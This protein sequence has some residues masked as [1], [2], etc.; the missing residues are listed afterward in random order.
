MP[1][2]SASRWVRLTVW[3]SSE[4]KQFLTGTRAGLISSSEIQYPPCRPTLALTFLL[5]LQTILPRLSGI[6]TVCKSGIQSVSAASQSVLKRLAGAMYR[7][8]LLLATA[9]ASAGQCGATEGAARGSVPNI[10]GQTFTA[11]NCLMNIDNLFVEEG[12][13]QTKTQHNYGDRL[14][15][16]ADTWSTVAAARAALPAITVTG[17]NAYY[18]STAGCSDYGDYFRIG[19]NS[20]KEAADLVRDHGGSV[21]IDDVE[22]V[23]LQPNSTAPHSRILYV[24]GNKIYSNASNIEQSLLAAG[25]SELSLVVN[26]STS[27]EEGDL[28]SSHK[29]VITGT[30]GVVTAVL[31]TDKSLPPVCWCRNTLLSTT[32]SYYDTCLN[33][34]SDGINKMIR[35][36]G[37]MGEPLGLGEATVVTPVSAAEIKA[38]NK[39]AD[40]HFVLAGCGKTNLRIIAGLAAGEGSGGGGGAPDPGLLKCISSLYEAIT[41]T[42]PSPAVKPAARDKRWS[43]MSFLFGESF[44]VRQINDNV[45]TITRNQE[46]L[47]NDEQT[48]LEN[49]HRISQFVDVL[50]AKDEDVM[51]QMIQITDQ[52][53]LHG[54]ILRRVNRAHTGNAKQ[55][56]SLLSVTELYYRVVDLGEGVDVELSSLTDAMVG[57]GG[58]HQHSAT[59]HLVCRR[60]HA[61]LSVSNSGE[62]VSSGT[63][64]LLG[65]RPV[66]T[67]SCLPRSDA[68]IMAWSGETFLYQGSSGNLVN[69]ERGSVVGWDCATNGSRC[70]TEN[71]AY[72]ELSGVDRERLHFITG[73]DGFWIGSSYSRRLSDSE[74]SAI[75]VVAGKPVHLNVGQ[76]PILAGKIRYTLQD[77]TDSHHRTVFT[78]KY[79]ENVEFER[80]SAAMD[81]ARE[82]GDMKEFDPDRVD[83][84]DLTYN[85]LDDVDPLLVST[86]ISWKWLLGLGLGLTAILLTGGIIIKWKFRAAVARARVPGMY[87]AAPTGGGD[88]GAVQAVHNPVHKPAVQPRNL[89]K[90]GRGFR[91]H[92]SERAKLLAAAAGAGPAVLQKPI[93]HVDPAQSRPGPAAQQG[94]PASPAHAYG[95]AGGDSAND[96]ANLPVGSGPTG[97]QP[98]RSTPAY[99]AREVRAS[100]HEFNS[101]GPGLIADARSD[102]ADRPDVLQGVERW[103]KEKC[104]NKSWD[105]IIFNREQFRAALYKVDA[106]PYTLETY[107]HVASRVRTSLHDQNIA[108]RGIT[109]PPP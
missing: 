15:V 100:L 30:D 23:G 103:V 109:D 79:V 78:R 45:K 48:L 96:Y 28:L 8:V 85:E 16:L 71:G 82:V 55:I 13:L 27:S 104:A 58:C 53:S 3:I 81:L 24:I 6:T 66:V 32:I 93:L 107:E 67:P 36:A 108:V 59:D 11:A 60:T 94:R 74:G 37:I 73:M 25:V 1:S 80:V 9:L 101:C 21:V 44:D 77:V 70:K 17:G 89:A 91:S 39:F 40:K 62:T 61:T 33:I 31:V 50:F 14:V 88:G 4:R 92:S 69:P 95:A 99:D 90:Q 35:F 20:L 84:D 106:G 75:D 86:G 102:F 19:P 87:F 12:S 7:T 34:L 83:I 43:V 98:A 22:V 52:V 68:T 76:F 41:W 54:Y 49:E 38:F 64:V 47:L 46:K 56:R 26:K 72:T 57:K 105:H 51:E 29:V 65:R 63:G 5:A 2:D 10:D 97:R 42:P 18:P